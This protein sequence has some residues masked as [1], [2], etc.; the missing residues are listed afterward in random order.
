M[1]DDIEQFQQRPSSRDALVHQL[2]FYGGWIAFGVGLVT[3]VYASFI[4][5]GL[6]F[7]V[8]GKKA[9]DGVPTNVSYRRGP[10][11]RELE[12]MSPTQ[13]RHHAQRVGL[14]LIVFGL[15][16]TLLGVGLLALEGRAPVDG[17]AKVG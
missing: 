17:T 9:Y 5:S 7:V 4:V 6:S 15:V 11:L 10:S 3:A 12:V 16:I 14:R 8:S 2:C 1:S 13:R